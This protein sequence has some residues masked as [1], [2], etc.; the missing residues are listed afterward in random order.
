MSTYLAYPKKKDTPSR[1]VRKSDRNKIFWAN[2][3]AAK[4]RR[5]KEQEDNGE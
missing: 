5:K 1:K 2:K 3:K 4:L